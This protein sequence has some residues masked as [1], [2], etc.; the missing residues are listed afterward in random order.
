[1]DSFRSTF[2]YLPA[3]RIAICRRHQQGILK[4]QLQTHL[5]TKHQGLVRSKRRH[6]IQAV[7]EDESLHHWANHADDVVFPRQDA[8]PLP[9]LPVY[10]NG[11]KCKECGHI[12]THIK[13]MQQ[14][15]RQEHGWQGTRQRSRSR[16]P[17]D[18]L[19]I[20]SINLKS[21]T[22]LDWRISSTLLIWLIW[23]LIFWFLIEVLIELIRFWSIIT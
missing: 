21:Q 11:L 13:G 2:E 17:A 7:G 23:T 3:Y 20:K 6:I 8:A 10:K 12:Y 5:D 1:M 22:D 9:H 19:T 16:P 14:H 4:S 15:C 18:L